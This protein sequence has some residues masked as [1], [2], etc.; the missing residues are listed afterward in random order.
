MTETKV[1]AGED[2]LLLDV[3]KIAINQVL[4]NDNHITN[5]NHVTNKAKRVKPISYNDRD[6]TDIIQYPKIIHE[7]NQQGGRILNT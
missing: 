6:L 2:E 3:T 1:C 5:K 4:E 7:L